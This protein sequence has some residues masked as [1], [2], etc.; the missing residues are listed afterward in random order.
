MSYTNDG[1]ESCQKLITDKPNQVKITRILRCVK[2]QHDDFKCTLKLRKYYFN[3]NAHC[4]DF[5]V[6]K[7]SLKSS[8]TKLLLHE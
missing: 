6:K 4:V 5:L 8:T 2:C 7:Q 1:P 3:N